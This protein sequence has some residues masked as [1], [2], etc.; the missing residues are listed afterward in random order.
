MAAQGKQA[1]NAFPGFVEVFN[2]HFELVAVYL[3]GEVVQL[4]LDQVLLVRLVEFFIFALQLILICLL[5]LFLR[6]LT[7][8]ELVVPFLLIVFLWLL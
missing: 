5:L 6:I 4:D 3:F 7:F 1:V 2:G 8:F